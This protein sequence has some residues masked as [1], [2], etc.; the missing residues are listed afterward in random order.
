MSRLNCRDIY[1]FTFFACLSNNQSTKQCQ[2]SGLGTV[3][4][5]SNTQI[6]PI[7]EGHASLMQIDSRLGFKPRTFCLKGNFAIIRHCAANH[8]KMY[9]HTKMWFPWYP[10]NRNNSKV[11]LKGFEKQKVRQFSECQPGTS[12]FFMFNNIT[13]E[14]YGMPLILVLFYYL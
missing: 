9:R 13:V 8:I 2:Q 7:H 12:L 3:G 6:K 5:S 4:G 1:P 11:S 10:L 14:K